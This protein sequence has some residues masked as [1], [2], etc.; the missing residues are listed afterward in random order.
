MY[1]LEKSSYSNNCFK[2]ILVAF[3][4]LCLNVGVH[5]QS[6]K[7]GINFQAI[8]KDNAG[9]P[10]NN[11]KIYLMTTIENGFPNGNIV[12]GEKHT[13]ITNELGIFNIVIGKGERF[14]GANNLY[15]IDWAIATY[16]IHLK[17]SVVPISPTIEWDHEK[18]WIDLGTVAF[19][20]VPYAIQSLNSNTVSI[21]SN[22][23][24]LKLNNVD[25]ATM[26]A[27]YAYKNV[28]NNLSLS[29]LGKL[30]NAD[31]TNMLIPYHNILKLKDSSYYVTPYQLTLK[32]FDT[33]SISNRINLRLSTNDTSLMLNNYVRLS[34]LNNSLP[35]KLNIADTA[36]MLSSRFA[37]DTLA[38]SN[39]INEK[40]I[41]ANKSSDVSL[42]SDFNDTKYPSVKAIKTYVD[43]A[44]IAGAPDA[45]VSNKGLLMLAGDLTGTASIP[46]IAL[47]S[48]STN[49][50]QDAAIT[51]A[52]LASGINASKVGLDNLTNNAQVYSINGLTA[53]VQSFSNPGTAGIHPNWLSAG[54]SHTLNIPMASAT[55]VDAGLI[56]KIE[57]DHFTNAYLN[58][59]TGI[60]TN[61]HSGS[62]LV[63]GQTINIPNYTLVGLAGN[64]SANTFFAGPSS[65]SAGA[66]SFR[67]LVSGDIPNNA[68]NTSGNAATASKLN[69][70]ILINGISFDG[71]ADLSITSN[72]P[73]AISFDNSGAGA[74]SGISF[75]GAAAKTISYN[76]IGAAPSL[77]SSSI[78]TLGTIST[79]VWNANIIGANYGGAG[80]NNGIL[81][82]DGNGIVSTAVAGVHYQSPL[83]FTSPL[84]NTSNTISIQPATGVYDGYLT[85]LDWTSFNNKI[86]LS[87]KAANN[88]VASLDGNGK[89]P[90]SQIPAISFSS[91]YVVT[92][93]SAMLGLS[94]AVVGSIAIRTDNSR[95]YVLSNLPASNLS[96][97]LQ[98]L[99]PAAVSS[100][101]GH[102]ESNITLTSSDIAEGT[103]LYYTDTRAKAAIGATAPVI[104]ASSTGLIS[105]NT[106]SASSAGY[107]SA[108]DWSSFNNKLST[109]T[110]QTAN[111]FFAGPSVGSN[112][113]P[114]FRTIV[115]ADIPTL[116][117]NTTGNA[118]TATKLIA[119]KNINGVAFDGSADITI[120]STVP[121]TLNFNTSGTGATSPFSFDGSIARTI[122]YNTIGAAPTIGSNSLTTLGTITTGTWSATVIDASHGGAGT[123]NGILKANGSGLVAAASAG[124]DFEN[125]LTFSMPLTRSTNTISMAAATSSNNGYLTS[126]DWSLFNNKQS[127]LIA[128]TGVSISGGNTVAIGQAVSTSA[129]PTFTG[130]TLS[131]LNVAG[132][133]TNTASGVLGTSPSTGTGNIV[134][135]TSPTLVTPVLGDAIATSL[136]VGTVTA[137]SVNVNGD[138]AAKRFKLTMPT[139][140]TAAATTTI[141]LSAG[142]V[143]TVNMGLN[144]ATL[145]LNNPVVGTYLLKFVQDAT[146]TRDVVFPVAWKWAGGVIPSLTN[147][148]NKIDIVTLIYDGN[149]YY[150]TIVQN[151]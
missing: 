120:T 101:N 52:K 46:L 6:I 49:K 92:S 23:L 53:Q 95:N 106:A 122:S 99:M 82:A 45:T 64:L 150:S 135:A 145:T 17:M 19:G 50:I 27:P 37:R 78:N 110:A 4:L 112:A 109:Y 123:I 126:T 58:S 107:L 48:I 84:I 33:S 34:F 104:Y 146:G 7:P 96:N 143:F 3:F 75:N 39:R 98:L 125:P 149:T 10:A 139:A 31:T 63:A 93:E 44:L 88:G 77:G 18:E 134:R 137:T 59:I 131:G 74:L 66:A 94:V 136:N 69:T 127:T 26:L 86:D 32:T 133:V 68:A 36:F 85:A 73:N 20:V 57:Y 72:I 102:T 121:N 70:A 138:L 30:N 142:N 67:N 80:N 8:A 116:N 97:W 54:S 132:I 140:I 141:D 90:T 105:M 129:A 130:A 22:T 1:K 21:D 35:L 87:Q 91:G 124:S 5:A 13:A 11:R 115:A 9:N 128:S 29:M 71:S 117:Q 14:V 56:S 147:T 55:S 43:A 40:E 89:I 151:F 103:R 2:Y 24:K 111:S 47:N 38:L 108:T 25:T 15:E 51:D 79:G 100:V 61:G 62:A 81:K 114:N 16:Y 65:G 144:V 41:L 42:V 12:F 119:T 113:T 118:A 76:S 83:S 60:T 28:V 148:A